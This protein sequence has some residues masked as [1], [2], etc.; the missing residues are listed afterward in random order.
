MSRRQ[1]TLSTVLYRPLDPGALNLIPPPRPSGGKGS[2]LQ[3]QP[4]QDTPAATQS[5][6]PPSPTSPVATTA[7]TSLPLTTSAAINL[8][9]APNATPLIILPGETEGSVTRGSPRRTLLLCSMLAVCARTCCF[10]VLAV[11]F[12]FV[13]LQRCV[14]LSAFSF[15]G[16]RCQVSE[17]MTAMPSF[18]THLL[19]F[20]EIRIV[21]LLHQ[22]SATEAL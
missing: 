10:F 15:S 12:L 17:M 18:P 13:S 9:L 7:A 11:Y 4:Q 2:R 19:G 6:S 22:I 21:Q 20:P 16:R 14:S 1:Q 8:P 5:T 3:Q